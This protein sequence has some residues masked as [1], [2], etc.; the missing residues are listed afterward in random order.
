MLGTGLSCAGADGAMSRGAA[1][2]PASKAFS[3]VDE[4]VIMDILP[5]RAG[6]IAA[7]VILP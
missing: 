1:S 2:A 4:R 5:V 6:A 7:P 3:K